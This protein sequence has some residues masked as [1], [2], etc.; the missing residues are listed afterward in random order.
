LYS[1]LCHGAPRCAKCVLHEFYTISS[2]VNSH[3]IAAIAIVAAIAVVTAVAVVA[4]PPPNK[5]GSQ[6][7]LSLL[8]LMRK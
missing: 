2:T 8:L 1:P 3:F 5:R 6:L 7:L 4:M